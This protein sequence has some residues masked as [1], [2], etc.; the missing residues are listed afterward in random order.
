MDFEI[1]LNVQKHPTL[2]QVYPDLTLNFF[3]GLLGFISIAET[4]GIQIS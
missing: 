4:N 3:L 1:L 2:T